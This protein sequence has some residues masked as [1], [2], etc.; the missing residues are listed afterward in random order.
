M[1]KAK[2]LVLLVASLHV[3]KTRTAHGTPVY[4]ISHIY[5]LFLYSQWSYHG[6]I[7]SLSYIM[8][9]IIYYYII[10]SSYI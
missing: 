9:I 7:I 6:H 3:S 1:G 5:I 4:H 2:H 8:I 10:Y